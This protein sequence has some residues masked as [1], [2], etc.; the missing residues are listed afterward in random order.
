MNIVKRKISCVLLGGVL[1][2]AT[3]AASLFFSTA[4]VNRAIYPVFGV[5]VSNYQGDIN[6][7]ELEA[8]NVSF[9]FIKATE[10]SG[11]T[12]ESVRRNLD[13]AAG[14]GIKVS[15]YHF[16]SFD[17]AGETQ[18]DNFISSVMKDEIDMPPVIDIEYYG[19]K[20]RHKPSQEETEAILRPLLERLEAHYGVKP[21]IY[22]TLPVYFRYIRKNFSD[23]PLWIRS[24]NCEPDL[25]NWKF[26]QYSDKGTLTGYDGDEEHIDLN[27]YNGT[28]EDFSREFAKPSNKAEK[29]SADTERKAN[30]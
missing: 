4:R 24:V 16:F 26:W 9:A 18:A 11:H 30:K 19:D 14:T 21:I 6:W 2:A 17:S 27:V 10:G 7:Q 22:S 13:R 3:A 15:A 20:R 8:Q 12:D 23:Y 28:A 1:T 25:I 29:S 5:D